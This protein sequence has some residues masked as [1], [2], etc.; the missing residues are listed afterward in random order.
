M[1]ISLSPTSTIHL[2]QGID[3]VPMIRFPPGTWLIIGWT[4]VTLGIGFWATFIANL[5]AMEQFQLAA[6]F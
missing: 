2:A 1:P 5:G 6:T 3:H 4:V